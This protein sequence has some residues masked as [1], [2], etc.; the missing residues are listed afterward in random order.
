MRQRFVA[1]P[2]S[3]LAMLALMGPGVAAA[4]DQGSAGAVYTLSNA[5]SG[6]AVMAFRRQADGSLSPMATYATGGTGTGTGLG[7]QGALTLSADGRW[8]LAVDPGSNDVASFSVLPDGRLH[9]VDRA[10]S[11]GTLPISVTVHGNLVYV[12]NAGGSGNIAGLRLRSDGA[13][14]PLAL[15]RRPLTSNASGPAQVSFNPRGDLLVVTEKAA[16]QIATYDVHRNG[17]TSG[18]RANTSAGA[19]PFGFAFDR[20]GRLIVSEAFGGAPDASAVSSYWLSSEGRARVVSASVGTTQTAACWV[21][22]TGDGRYAYTTNTGSGSVS[23][24]AIGRGGR[25]TLLEAAA[26]A[27]GP[28]PIDAAFSRDSRN[29]Y[30]L[31]SGAH[32]IAAFRVGGDGGLSSASGMGGLP[33]SSVGLAAR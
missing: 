21:V 14:A 10:P 32:S 12:L 20:G 2:V 27:T 22:T 4:H 5:A 13:L 8:L 31:S 28:G 7:S 16:N 24:F 3:L 18:P 33:A 11:G 15:S 30:V 26:G 9:L 29:L 19:T 6:N 1:V 25:L 17:R 23:S